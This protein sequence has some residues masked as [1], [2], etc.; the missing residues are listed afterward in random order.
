MIQYAIHEQLSKQSVTVL[1]SD[2]SY[3]YNGLGNSEA[4]C[5]ITGHSL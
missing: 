5:S 4:I 1:T 3:T 2:D